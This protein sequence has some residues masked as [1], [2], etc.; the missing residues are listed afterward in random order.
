ML[1]GSSLLCSDDVLGGDA[2]VVVTTQDFIKFW[3]D[4]FFRFCNA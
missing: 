2:C 3:G 1:N 4:F